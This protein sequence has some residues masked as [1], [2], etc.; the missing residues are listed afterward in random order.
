MHSKQ[1]AF[2]VACN[3]FSW[4]SDIGSLLAWRGVF[5][6]A[7]CYGDPWD[8]VLRIDFAQQ[9]LTSQAARVWTGSLQPLIIPDPLAHCAGW[10]SAQC[11]WSLA[12]QL[13]IVR[14]EH[15]WSIT[16]FS[17]TVLV[18]VVSVSSHLHCLCYIYVLVLNTRILYCGAGCWMLHAKH[19]RIV[20]ITACYFFLVQY[21][22]SS[23]LVPGRYFYSL[24]LS[25]DD[26]TVLEIMVRSADSGA[27]HWQDEHMS[28]SFLLN[29]WRLVWRNVQTAGPGPWIAD[30][31][32]IARQEGTKTLV[33]MFIY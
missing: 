32:E 22:Y 6:I 11:T 19:P 21:W 3:R 7:A 2:V 31:P 26:R 5:S 23:T 14:G 27:E 8:G 25:L 9:Q 12:E 18:V 4:W 24:T 10:R 16:T 33:R 28:I 20:I 29:T 13:T 30:L 15:R 1:Y 17:G